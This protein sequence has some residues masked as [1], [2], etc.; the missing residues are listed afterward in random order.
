MWAR[1]GSPLGPQQRW[2]VPL[3]RASLVCACLLFH[4][5]TST[6]SSSTH[7]STDGT[8]S[9]SS[10][11]DGRFS[12]PALLAPQP[13]A[14]PDLTGLAEA[15]ELEAALTYP[16]AQ[17]PP[18]SD[19]ADDRL[20]D[21]TDPGTNAPPPTAF[22]DP[23]PANNNSR[24]KSS[25]SSSSSSSIPGEW[26]PQPGKFLLAYCLFGRLSN[27]VTGHHSPFTPPQVAPL[28]LRL[29]APMPLCQC[30][31]IFLCHC[32]HWSLFVFVT[33]L[34][35]HCV[36]VSPRHRVTVSLCSSSA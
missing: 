11:N 5:S 17:T 18:L 13:Y 30:T 23:P 10:R 26:Q 34:P 24:N 31:T 1:R 14:D 2:G 29:N 6:R 7:S 33:V 9:T 22:S 25:S 3:L 27:E 20:G 35:C 8:K 16:S 36:T 32:L 21:E 4:T 19:A 28:P 15:A 12:D